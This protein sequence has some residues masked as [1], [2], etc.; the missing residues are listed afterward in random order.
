MVPVLQTARLVLRGLTPADAPALFAFRSD[1]EAERFNDPPLR[2]VAQA[3]EL[4]ER[5]A[6]D[7]HTVGA[8]HWGVTLAGT[9][10]V[11]GLLGYNSRSVP[12]ARASIGYDL[13]RPLWGRGLMSE[14]M[15]VVLDHGFGPLALN[16]VEAHTDDANSA[17]IR[18]LRRLGFWREGTFHERFLEDG[19]Y[20][21]IALFVMLRRDRGPR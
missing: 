3:R 18:M 5:L 16:R 2:S 13:A 4:V 12:H 1:A 17:S 6:A 11:V 7:E 19:E 21:D 10:T 8:L 20:H 14:A 15:S 9:D